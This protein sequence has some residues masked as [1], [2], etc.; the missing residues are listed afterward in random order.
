MIFTCE[1]CNKN[2]NSIS[3]LN[4]HTTTSKCSKNQ[5]CNSSSNELPVKKNSFDILNH[6]IDH[7]TNIVNNQSQQI[8]MLINIISNNNQFDIIHNSSSVATE[9][10]TP[11]TTENTTNLTPITTEI[12]TNLTPITTENTTTNSIIITP[13]QVKKIKYKYV[14]P[15]EEPIEEEVKEPIKEV[16]NTQVNK[17]EGWTK[18]QLD[19][20][21]ENNRRM[22]LQHFHNKPSLIKEIVEEEHIV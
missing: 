6:K 14:L 21:A 19:E 18:E 3:S 13:I 9:N 2:Y 17:Y 4:K 15:V 7:L 8:T 22:M 12:T 10:L 1:K 5:S 16:K 20:D 11:I